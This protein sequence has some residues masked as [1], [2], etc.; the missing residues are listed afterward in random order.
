MKRWL[1]LCL[2]LAAC[3]RPRPTAKAP[4][5]TPETAVEE[6]APAVAAP[7]PAAVVEPTPH[8][9]V[10]PRDIPDDRLPPAIRE[11]KARLLAAVGKL[12]KDEAELVCFA[13]QLIPREEVFD[14]TNLPRRMLQRYTSHAITAEELQTIE[15]ALKELRR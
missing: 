8:P 4:Q 5:A 14:E 1:L 15:A 9:L 13:L 6:P 11:H 12:T 10:D 3:S 2:L 7:A